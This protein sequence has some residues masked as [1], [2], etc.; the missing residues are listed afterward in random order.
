MAV[1]FRLRL[2][3]CL[4]GAVLAWS[5]GSRAQ[6]FDQPPISYSTAEP[7]NAVSRLEARLDAGEAGLVH[8][9]DLGYLR[10]LLEELK[11]PQ[12]SQTLVYSKTSLQRHRITP[13][14]PRA[15]YFNDD[16]Y[17]GYCRDGEVLEI[18]A[19]DP[20]LGTV[21]YT[22]EQQPNDPPRLMRQTD[23]CLL[24]HGSSHNQ[25]VP[26]HV[27]R[28]TYVDSAGLPIL[29]A[30]SFRIDHTSPL[31]NRWGG[32]YVTGSHG[33]QKHLGNLIVRGRADRDQIDNSDGMNVKDLGSRFDVSAYLTPHSDIVALMLLEHQAQA[34]NLLARANYLGRIAIHQEAALN[35][36][37]SQ[38]ADHRW[39]STN[40]R[41]RDAGEPLV[42]YLLCSE[43]AGLTA[44]LE[45][46][47]GFAEEFMARGPRDALGRSLRDLDLNRRLFKYPCSYLIYSPEFD[48]LPTLVKDYVWRRIDEVLN[49]KE[50]LKE[51][52][53]LS[54]ADRQ[55]I[56][57][58]LLS[59]KADLPDSWRQAA[60]SDGS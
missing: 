5:A 49:G 42:R 52:S 43:E 41:I 9:E 13:G 60:G 53:H 31:A 46:T 37:L 24:C 23:S 54:S 12:S 20:Q 59:T 10:S 50:Q 34:H 6:D 22:L 29:S 15:I 4:A 1:K 21:F 57:E 11:V 40:S 33:D 32:W 28:S 48:G 39:E 7:H 44:P 47:S 18:S 27:V 58:I 30:G 35:R 19:A 16:V 3:V 26:G 38:P 45:G 51:F 25:G 36:E 14:T 2:G 8:E 55:A 17:V 56:R